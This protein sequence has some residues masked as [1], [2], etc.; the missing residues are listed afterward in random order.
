MLAE[1][2]VAA[3][4]NKQGHTFDN[5]TYRLEASL[6]AEVLSDDAGESQVDLVMG[7]TDDWL[8]EKKN[9][10]SQYAE[11]VYNKGR[12]PE[13]DERAEEASERIT[14]RLNGSGI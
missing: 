6:R 12:N 8:D 3:Q 4:E 10:S 2:E 1:L 14:E 7:S 5:Y 13:F 11:K 9:T